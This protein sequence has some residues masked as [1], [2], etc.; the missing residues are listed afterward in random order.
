MERQELFNILS[1][2]IRRRTEVYENIKGERMLRE[3]F[4]TS[5]A[6]IIVFSG[7]YG[8]VMGTY[9]GGLQILYDAVKIPLLLLLSMYISLPTYYILNGV[10]GGELSLRQLYALFQISIAVMSSMLMAFLPVT[11]FFILT[12]FERSFVMYA[13]NVLL[14]VL[15]FGIGGL[16]ALKYLLDG[17]KY[18]HGE[19]RSWKPAML[20]GSCVLTFVGTQLAWVLRPYFHLSIDFISR[21]RGNFYIALFELVLRLFLGR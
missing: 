6:A 16:F 7:L 11:L 17:F 12:T 19:N 3:Y 9:A 21:P 13:F 20:L 1:S 5:T 2:F 10:L 14:N 18:V 4:I 8:A 15:F